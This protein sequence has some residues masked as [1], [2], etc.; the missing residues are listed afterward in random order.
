MMQ[1][2][3]IYAV[4]G[5]IGCGKTAVSDI[6]KE[7]GYSVFSC[8][9]IYAELTRGGTL[10]KELEKAFGGV[11][12]ANGSLDRAALSA[13][14]FSDSSE[15]EKLNRITHPLIMSELLTRARSAQDKIVFCEVPLL[16]ENGFEGL[17]DDVIVVM[18]PL[19]QRLE[20]VEK[21]SNLTRTE[22]LSRINSQYDYDQND[23]TKYYVV[24][25]D[26]TIKDLQEKIKK[27]LKNITKL[28]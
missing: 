19:N 25:N 8:D 2:K 26:G 16:F 3:R 20:A 12:A 27:I 6:L 5:G 4:T 14:V 1:N 9:G 21:R 23:F 7:E 10:V 13:K 22:V 24:H 15:L 18:R 28:T 17:F 11:T